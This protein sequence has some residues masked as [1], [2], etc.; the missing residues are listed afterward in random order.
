VKA[1]VKNV[2]EAIKSTARKLPTRNV[3]TPMSL[4][5]I[6]DLDVTEELHEKEVNFSGVDWCVEVGD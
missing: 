5:Y 1:A 4:S 3:E 6:S 2:E